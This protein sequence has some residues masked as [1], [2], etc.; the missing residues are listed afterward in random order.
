MRVEVDQ[1]LCIS[2]GLCVDECPE[3]FEWNDD[4]KAEE[5]A[6]EVPENSQTEAKQAVEGCPTDAIK[7]L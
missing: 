5:K 3:V 2:C 4:G 6:K 7:E 1:D